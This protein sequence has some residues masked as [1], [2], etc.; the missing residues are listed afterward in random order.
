[1]GAVRVP[2]LGPWPVTLTCDPHQG[3]QPLGSQLSPHREPRVDGFRS[4]RLSQ[5]CSPW[6]CETV[7]PTSGSEPE[8]CHSPRPPSAAC[9]R[10]L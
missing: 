1:M 9:S 6:E 3:P 5:L 8:I 10:V 4:L 7:P 2:Q